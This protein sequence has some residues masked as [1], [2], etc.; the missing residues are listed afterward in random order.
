MKYSIII[1]FV[2]FLLTNCKEKR[3]NQIKSN[4][5]IEKDYAE[6]QKKMTDLDTITVWISIGTCFP[7]MTSEKL[8][9]TKKKG[10]IK[11]IPEFNKDFQ[12]SRKYIKQSTIL[13]SENDTIWKFGEFLKNNEFRLEKPDRNQIT[14]ALQITCNSKRIHFYTKR[15]SDYNRLLKGYFETMRK[16]K[17]KTTYY[18]PKNDFE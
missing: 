17:P 11:I 13:I 3:T 12:K 15:L 18:F 10:K 2:F 8:T 7:P 1:I 4:F 9:I 6:F 5:D 14:G 16:I